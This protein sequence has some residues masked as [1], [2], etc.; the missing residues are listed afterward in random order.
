M[1]YQP[2]LPP[3]LFSFFIESLWI[4]WITI[5]HCQKTPPQTYLRKVTALFVCFPE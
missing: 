5:V 1:A 4:L 2:S 3:S